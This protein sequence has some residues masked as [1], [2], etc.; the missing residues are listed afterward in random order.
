MQAKF[1]KIEGRSVP[2]F[3]LLALM[4]LFALAGLLSTW[5]M[6]K[7]GIYM[8]GMT[9]RIP[10]GLQVIF[11]VFYIGLSAG[12]LVI[13]SLYGIFGKIEYK[14]FARVAVFLAFLFLV[15]ALLSIMSDWGRI[16]RVF[17]PFSNFNF[18][19]MLS[20]NPFLYNTYMAVCVIY[21]W[22]M[23][24]EKDKWVKRIALFAV[25]WAIGVH[26]G[27]GAIFG[28][29]QRELYQSALS[30]PS[31]ISAALSSGTACMIL[32]ILALF[33]FTK[34]PLDHELIRR[35][36]KLLAIFIVVV[37]YFLFVENAYRWYLMGSREAGLYF[38]FSGD[39]GSVFWI[40]MILIGSILP[41]IFLFNPATGRSIPWI[42]AASIMVVFGVLCERYLIVIPGQTH[43]PVLFPNMEF[44]QSSVPEGIV[45]YHITF[46]EVLQALGVVGIIGLTFL[47]GLKFLNFLPT[48]AKLPE[49]A[50]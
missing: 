11:A 16:D 28:F 40:G 32:V 42:V 17:E 15:A 23:F 27:T 50:E 44:V 7:D 26:S 14:P 38:L 10:W 3:A 33:K 29:T 45:Q 2:Y 5:M 22:A 25:I 43:P 24:K 13:S 35:L 19:S 41:A 37:L 34:R 48:E 46:Y 4:G 39:I 8:T 31:F 20:I 18:L 47:L 36:G 30:P 21:M 1:E 6:Y 12:S 9:N 49:S